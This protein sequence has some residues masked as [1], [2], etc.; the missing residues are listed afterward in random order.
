[1][2]RKSKKNPKGKKNAKRTK[3]ESESDESK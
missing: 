3:Y 2:E 1:M